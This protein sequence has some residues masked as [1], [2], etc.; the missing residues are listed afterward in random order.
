[1]EERSLSAVAE[2]DVVEE[3]EV[4]VL[5]AVEAMTAEAIMEAVEVVEAA[6]VAE[7]GEAIANLKEKGTGGA[8]AAT[9]QTSLGEISAIGKRFLFVFPKRS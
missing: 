8:Q 6:D 3:A 2:E 4:V 9:T 5:V 1:M 7:T